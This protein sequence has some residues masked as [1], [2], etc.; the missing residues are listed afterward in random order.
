[1]GGPHARLRL[2][3][4]E[5]QVRGAVLSWAFNQSVGG[6]VGKERAQAGI[7]LPGMWLWWGGDHMGHGG[8]DGVCGPLQFSGSCSQ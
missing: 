8:V 7:W 1:M 4:R 6:H 3:A 2:A 5:G